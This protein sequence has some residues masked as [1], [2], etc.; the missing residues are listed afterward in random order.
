M[1]IYFCPLPHLFGMSVTTTPLF[2]FKVL[3]LS[4]ML[5]DDKTL[6]FP[7]YGCQC[8]LQSVLQYNR[9]L[10]LMNRP[11]E[12]KQRTPIQSTQLVNKKTLKTIIDYSLKKQIGVFIKKNSKVHPSARNEVQSKVDGSL[13]GLN[14]LALFHQQLA[15]HPTR[16]DETLNCVSRSCPF[17]LISVLLVARDGSWVQFCLRH[18][19]SCS[20]TAFIIAQRE[21][22]QFVTLLGNSTL[23]K[24][25]HIH[26]PLHINHPKYQANIEILKPDFK[27]NN[28]ERGFLNLA[29]HKGNFYPHRSYEANKTAAMRDRKKCICVI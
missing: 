2:L 20:V 17:I 21:R 13:C 16:N 23:L 28:T 9:H 26:Q 5:K 22:Q 1:L 6:L 12:K 3:Q 8:L 19:K 7:Q 29:A 25:H 18:Y 10:A 15:D 4:P 24:S 14:A 11:H 27:N